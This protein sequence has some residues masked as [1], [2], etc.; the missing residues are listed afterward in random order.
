MRRLI[1]I[2]TRKTTDKTAEQVSWK[3][4]LAFFTFTFLIVSSGAIY[5]KADQI[6]DDLAQYSLSKG[7]ALQMIEVS[8]RTIQNLRHP[9]STDQMA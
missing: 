8:G 2:W 7:F 4:N 3:H 1:S 9:L 5:L 6:N